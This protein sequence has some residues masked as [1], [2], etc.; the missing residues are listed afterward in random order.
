MDKG[1]LPHHLFHGPQGDG[2][3][4]GPFSA[5]HD[6]SAGLVERLRAIWAA[7]GRHNFKAHFYQ[8]NLDPVLLNGHRPVLSHLDPQ[9]NNFLV[10]RIEL[11]PGSNVAGK[12]FDVAL[13]Y[14]EDAGWYPSSWEYSAVFVAFGWGDAWPK[15]LEEIVDPWP[16]EAAMLRML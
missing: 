10:R 9:R 11:Q 14:W 15:R 4:C 16:S 13:V 1:P 6:L 12:Q 3:I 8:R 5:E 7:N 2:A